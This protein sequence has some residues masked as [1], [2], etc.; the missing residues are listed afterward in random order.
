MS[1]HPNTDAELV[2]DYLQGRRQA[3]DVLAERYHRRLAG[4]VYHQVRNVDDAL[5]ISQNVWHRVLRS[6]ANYRPADGDFFTWLTYQAYS[7]RSDFFR[8]RSAQRTV[9]LGDAVAALEKELQD[10]RDPAEPLLLDE[11]SDVLHSLLGKLSPE[12]RLVLEM[13]FL[14]GMSR[15]QTADQL[16]MPIGTVDRRQHA[17]LKELRALL[18]GRM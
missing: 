9:S 3:M 18:E 14:L 15:Q 13:R 8:R 5:E 7:C 16:E 11:S 17:A 2:S 10:H 1:V 4:Y 6:V 12:S